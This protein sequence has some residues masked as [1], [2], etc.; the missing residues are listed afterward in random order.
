MDRTNHRWRVVLR[1]GILTAFAL[2][3]LLWAYPLAQTVD[4][5]F[6]YLFPQI[7]F[8]Q[9]WKASIVVVNIGKNATSVQLLAYDP[10]GT[11]IQ[12]ASA[13]ISLN[14]KQQRNFSSGTGDW[15]EGTSSLKVEADGPLLSVLVPWSADGK[16]LEAIRP[17]TAP[18][19]VVT[20]PLIEKDQPESGQFVFLNTGP[21]ETTLEITA[22]DKDGN[23]LG[24]SS[25]P[26]L[27]P[28]ASTKI[29][30]GDLFSSSV[31][32]ST[33]AVQAVADEPIAG[34]LL[35]TSDDLNEVA[36]LSAPLRQD[37]Q[38]F[39]PVFQQAGNITLWSRVGLFNPRDGP[40]SITVEAF[41]AQNR[42]LGL[43]S[44]L[45]SLNGLSSTF[46]STS[47]LGGKVPT[48][49][50]S[51]AITADEPINSYTVIGALDAQGL[52]VVP[53]LTEN[54]SVSNYEVMGSNDGDVLVA[55]PHFVD[56]NSRLCVL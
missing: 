20:L 40:V 36:A 38:F 31:L 27:S 24:G 53:A 10:D 34:M 46:F 55:I 37:Q 3:G 6:S 12:E 14:P 23:S 2:V 54:D 29:E 56:K 44:D 28:M 17:V 4:L 11:L 26:A 30:I 16:G 43:L 35:S 19:P 25:L 47:N 9:G 45:T 22:L 41:D 5:P 51:L 52:T 48:N 7:A 42:S 13:G 39:V 18:N 33:A 32:S 15:P 49:T 21:L 8:E 50:V 1:N